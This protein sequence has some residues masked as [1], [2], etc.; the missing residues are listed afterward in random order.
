MSLD[1]AHCDEGNKRGINEEE[2]EQDPYNEEEKKKER[3]K[4]KK[5]RRG[6]LPLCPYPLV[7]FYSLILQYKKNN[8]MLL[9]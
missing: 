4:K 2:D 6:P 1:R 9:H 8:K 5:Q 7:P 3:R